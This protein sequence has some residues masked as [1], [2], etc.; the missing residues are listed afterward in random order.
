MLLA[1]ICW[2]HAHLLATRDDADATAPTR[3]RVE[4]LGLA[5]V[6][7]AARAE[8]MHANHGARV[9]EMSGKRHTTI[10][11]STE[12]FVFFSGFRVFYLRTEVEGAFCC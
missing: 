10:T 8:A 7:I 9:H 6:Q 2:P 1:Q 3:N 5:P 12:A 11:Q 4:H